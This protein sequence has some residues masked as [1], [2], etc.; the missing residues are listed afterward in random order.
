MA[1]H[2]HTHREEE[3][4]EKEKM[5]SETRKLKKFV[6]HPIMNNRPFIHGR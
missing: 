3:E 5:V 4:E 2:T 1:T 6:R